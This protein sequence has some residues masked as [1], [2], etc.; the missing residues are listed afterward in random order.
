MHKSLCVVISSGKFINAGIKRNGD[1]NT[2]AQHGQRHRKVHEGNNLS[3]PCHYILYSCK[4]EKDGSLICVGI[5]EC[6]DTDLW[7]KLLLSTSVTIAAVVSIF[8]LLW[9]TPIIPML[10]IGAWCRPVLD[11]AWASSLVSSI[12]IRG[13]SITLAAQAWRPLARFS[14]VVCEDIIGVCKAT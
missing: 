2:H 3:A 13:A 8:T 11:L 4:S 14:F 10:H 12:V 9:I 7:M 1:K 5:K 6:G